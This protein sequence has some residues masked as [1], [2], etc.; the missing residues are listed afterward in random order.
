MHHLPRGLAQGYR[1][2]NHC[3][4]LEYARGELN[5]NSTDSQKDGFL[6]CYLLELLILSQALLTFQ[7]C[8]SSSIYMEKVSWNNWPEEKYKMRK[9]WF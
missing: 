8:L 5:F 4:A 3:F 7:Q 9:F 6:Q 1:I 2:P